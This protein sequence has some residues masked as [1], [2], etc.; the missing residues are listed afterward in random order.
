MKTISIVV[1]CFNEE[2]T[3]F[4]FYEET[5]KILCKMKNNSE[6]NLKIE[7][8]EFVFVDDGS[9]DKTLD[10][11]RKLSEQD[12]NVRYISFSR[13]FGK[14]AAL[15]A[16]LSKSDGQYIAV[17]D[18]DLQDP[19]SLLPAMLSAIQNEGYDCAATRRVTRKNE[20]PVRSFFARRF[21]KIM[22]KL[23]DVPVIDGARDFRLMT[24]KYKDAVLLL[25]ERNR[26][27][28]GIFPWVGFKTKWFDYENIERIAGKTKWSFWKLFLYSIDGIISF[29]TK[30]L[31]FSAI[32]G[33]VSIFASLILILFIAVRRIVFGDPVQGWA[34]LVCFITFFAGMQLTALGISGLY[35]SKIYTEVKHRPLY[36]IQEEK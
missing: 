8:F 7:S 31:V 35:I 15:F 14:E 29:S 13:N 24:K 5:K 20:P 6:E 26:F 25:S 18:A 22:G 11:L 17:M 21:Y 2:E 10:I 30:P 34:S 27:T 19:P 9:S 23:S 4:L 28:K 12:K 1:P 3:I 16:G 33:I 32:A 36:V